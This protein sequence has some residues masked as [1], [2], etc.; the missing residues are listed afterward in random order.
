MTIRGQGTNRDKYVI[1]QTYWATNPKAGHNKQSCGVL[2]GWTAD[3][4]AILENKRWGTILATF[5]NLN[6]HN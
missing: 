4:K 3:G 2:V 6:E 5:K 1:G